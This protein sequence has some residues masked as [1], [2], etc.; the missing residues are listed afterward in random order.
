[1]KSFSLRKTFKNLV[2]IMAIIGVIWILALMLIIVS[3]VV[4][5]N[6]FNH[7]II[8]VPEIAKNSIVGITFLQLPYVL[9]KGR[10]IRSTVIVDK[11]KGRWKQF[12]LYVTWIA[13]I[14]LFALLIYAIWPATMSSFMN[15][16]FT[17]EGSIRIPTFPTYFI[18]VFSSICM[19]IQSV[20]SLIDVQR[21]Q[22]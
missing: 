1:M 10:H 18:I 4:G 2:F 3:D 17:G 11:L 5:R 16:E 15:K 20:F 21:G 7:P 13:V 6:F 9:L 22:S 8:G 12:L 14:I 19:V